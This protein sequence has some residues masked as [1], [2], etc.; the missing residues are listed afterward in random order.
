MA[1]A[2]QTAEAVCAR[3]IVQ[4]VNVKSG[5]HFLATTTEC[6]QLKDVE[7][8]KM[9]KKMEESTPN[10]SKSNPN[11]PPARNFSELV[12]HQVPNLC[13]IPFRRPQGAA[14]I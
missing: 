5:F 8:K 7:M 12:F 4:L 1:W 9:V 11:L 3:Q 2:V 6:N 14:V 10:T 13:N